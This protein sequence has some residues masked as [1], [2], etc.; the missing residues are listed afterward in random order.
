M[1]TVLVVHHT[2]SPA[3]AQ[4]LESVT[5]GGRDA[6]ADAELAVRVTEMPALVAG[7]RDVLLTDA[8]VL[9]T[10]ANIGYMS[11]ALKHFFDQIYYPTLTSKPGLPVAFYIH[12]NDD[13]AGALAAIRRIVK[14][15]SW[16]E[17]AQ[18]VVVTG[19]V[20]AADRVSLSELGASA[21]GAAAGL[22]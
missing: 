1:S 14:G 5:Q 20:D 18:P 15:L 11:G 9:G 4:A 7:P 2:V 10:P 19:A 13:C 17:V 16:R 8:I 21:A 3:M 12:G 22:L 6:A